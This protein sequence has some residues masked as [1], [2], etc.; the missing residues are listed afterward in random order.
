[1]NTLKLILP[2]L[3]FLLGMSP[4]NSNAFVS[5][6]QGHKLQ[7]GDVVT[8]PWRTGLVGEILTVSESSRFVS[9][10]W[11]GPTDISSEVP[12]RTVELSNGYVLK[13]SLGSVFHLGCKV[14]YLANGSIGNVDR[15]DL[16][17]N[18]ID[19]DWNIQGTGYGINIPINSV[20]IE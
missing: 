11:N 2:A 5:D 3:F 16:E 1:M 10:A 18:T 12:G 19:V 6:R 14:K 20:T 17:K 15:I 8:F 7:V 4:L 13:D 9:I